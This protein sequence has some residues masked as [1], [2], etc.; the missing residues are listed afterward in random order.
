MFATR[1]LC[2]FIPIS[3]GLATEKMQNI[4]VLFLEDANPGFTNDL[5]FGEKWKAKFHCT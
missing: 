5:I 1:I 2:T 4:F 3:H